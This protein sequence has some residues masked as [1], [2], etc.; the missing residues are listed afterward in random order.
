MEKL[1]D[2]KDIYEEAQK[3][4]VKAVKELENET[5]IN[6][7]LS[8]ELESNLMFEIM[9]RTEDNEKLKAFYKD[10]ILEDRLRALNKIARKLDEEHLVELLKEKTD[11]DQADSR[12]LFKE[13]LGMEE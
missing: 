6:A 4:E 11:V 2:I 3:R 1:T 5:G 13:A 8:D 9:R 10:K 7:V 12:V